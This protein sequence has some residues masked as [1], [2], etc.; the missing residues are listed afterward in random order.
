M[1]GG[2]VSFFFMSQTRAGVKMRAWK[3]EGFKENVAFYKCEDVVALKN[4]SN[5]SLM[6]FIVIWNIRVLSFR[7]DLISVICSI[8]TEL[9]A[10]SIFLACLHVCYMCSESGRCTFH[11]FICNNNIVSH[12][13]LSLVDVLFLK[14]LKIVY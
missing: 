13:R 14:F 9:V 2:G 12:K 8:R 1:A 6:K 10:G 7:S 3:R 11:R 4:D 5:K